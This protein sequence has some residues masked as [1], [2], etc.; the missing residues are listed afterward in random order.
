[1]TGFTMLGVLLLVAGAV[2]AGTAPEAPAPVDKVVY[3]QPFTLEDGFAYPTR[4]EKPQVKAGYLLIVDADPELVLKRAMGSRILY[5]GK[6]TGWRINVGYP[7]GR[8]FVLVPAEL[9][10][11]GKVDLDLTKSRIWFGTHRF[12][13]HAD[14]P[15]IELEHDLAV[16]AGIAR[17][18]GR[19]I[20]AALREADGQPLAFRDLHELRRHAAVLM[21][22]YLPPE[23]A[24][25]AEIWLKADRLGEDVLR[26]V[27]LTV[28]ER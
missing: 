9:N 10:K 28:P 23:E 22:K 24:K 16:E 25:H 8:A 14:K 26:R 7:S 27:P 12:E 3:A 19:E 21:Q 18:P 17:R 20:D 1:M 4:K 5:V 15:R 2:M 11:A 6:Q 13:G